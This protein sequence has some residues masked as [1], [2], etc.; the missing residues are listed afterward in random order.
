MNDL[1]DNADARATLTR[2]SHEKAAEE[3]RQRHE[4]MLAA[5]DGVSRAVGDLCSEAMGIAVMVQAMHA[6][7]GGKRFSLWWRDCDMPAGWAEKYLKLSR[8]Q[9][10]LGEDRNQF[11]L[12][13]LLPEPEGSTEGQNQRPVNPLA[14]IKPVHKAA[15]ALSKI[16]IKGIGEADAVS[17]LKNLEPIEKLIVALR[18]KA[19][20]RF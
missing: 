15:A 18:E 14:W 20:A 11:V 4:A 5:R 13:G 16:D 2:A 1:K 17:V 12:I 10:R 7:L 19:G 9:A 8:S 3:I 6:D